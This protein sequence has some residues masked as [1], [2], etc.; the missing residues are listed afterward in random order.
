MAEPVLGQYPRRGNAFSRALGMGLLRL[1]GWRVVNAV[2]EVPKA[3]MIGGPHTSN[4]DGIIT[5]SAMV[6]VGLDAHVMIKDSAFKG[7]LGWLLRWMGALPIDRN[8]A[9]GVVEQTVAQFESHEQL[10]MI[11]SPEGTR[12][13]APQWKTGFYRIAEQAGVP[14]IVATADYQKKEVSFDFVVN[15][16]GDLDTD[17]RTIQEH[18]ATIHPKHLD[19]LSEPLKAIRAEKRDS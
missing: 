6:G 10:M 16:S 2:P 18:Y 12:S 14:I 7:P 17:L 1:L 19:K 5:L 9:G 8:K 15:P 11:V 13:G 3:V 4:W